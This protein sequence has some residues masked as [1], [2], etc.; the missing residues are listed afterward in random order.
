MG[1]K[2]DSVVPWGRSF[3]EYQRMF[4]LTTE[5]LK[6]NILD[7]GGGPAS[8]NAEMMRRGHRVTSCDPIYEFTAPQIEQRIQ[9]TYPVIVEGVRASLDSYVWHEMRS[10]E[11]L[12]NV[13][14]TA[15]QTF[16]QDFSE[17]LR[18][19]RYI[20]AELPQLPFKEQQFSLALC[21]HLLFTYS[22]QLGLE[23]HIAAV[24]ELCRV[25]AEVRIFPLLKID[26]EPSPHLQFVLDD[27]REQALKP[28][29]R[30]V[31]YE[32]Q[33]NGNQMLVISPK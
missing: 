9:E 5:D 26:G 10:P 15:M 8:F 23:F 7:C 21:G 28:V 11:E 24:R 25:A 31:D 16:L 17:G 20:M 13:R 30:T 3:H 2:L 14:K 33:K 18:E 27:L 19:Q 6:A 1:L 4:A 22:D 32:F 29:V 12:G